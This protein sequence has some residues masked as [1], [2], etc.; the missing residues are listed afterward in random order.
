MRK[1]FISTFIVFVI[2]SILTLLALV[3]FLG[4]G[5]SLLSSVDYFSGWLEQKT[6]LLKTTMPLDVMKQILFSGYSIP[7]ALYTASGISF[8]YFRKW[9]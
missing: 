3:T 2:F 7:L 5:L 6:G 8:C 9:L 1:S 4:V